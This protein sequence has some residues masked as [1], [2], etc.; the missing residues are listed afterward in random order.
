VNKTLSI[1][2]L[3]GVGVASAHASVYSFSFDDGNLMSQQSGAVSLVAQNAGSISYT[4]DAIN[5]SSA[6]VAKLVNGTPNPFSA[7]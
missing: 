2:L 1:A 4:T 6:K 5:G 3:A 7:S